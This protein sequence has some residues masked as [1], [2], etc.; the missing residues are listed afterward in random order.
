MSDIF[1]MKDID[2]SRIRKPMD[3]KMSLDLCSWILL[4][5]IVLG[6]FLLQ[7]W[8]HVQI[9]EAGYRIERVRSETEGIEHE[10]SLLSVERA[11]LRS[12]QRIDMIARAN[13]GM[14]LPSQEQRVVLDSTHTLG[15][16][17]VMAQVSPVE[18][19]VPVRARAGE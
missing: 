2:N 15:G 17:P 4:G 1:Y 7:A 19:T 9:R 10:N 12:P 5:F 6:A 16:Q 11:M 8:Q 14:T 18:G 3:L 13:L